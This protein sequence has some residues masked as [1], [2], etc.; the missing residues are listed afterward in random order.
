MAHPHLSAT[1]VQFRAR[2]HRTKNRIVA[3]PADVQERLGLSRRKDNDIV[4]LSLRKR[5]KGRWN[6]H[7]VKLTY[8]NEFAIPSDVT[9][10][11]AGDAVEVKIH[12]LYADVPRSPTPPRQRGAML[13]L[14]LASESRAGWRKDGST[15]LDEYLNE[16][17]G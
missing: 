13:L 17:I 14:A 8:D 15:R 4:L 11:R 5:G 9:L 2:V 10:V 7:Y 1:L 12:A 6:H 3:I 16:Q